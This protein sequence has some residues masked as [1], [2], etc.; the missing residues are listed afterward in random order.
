MVE[1]RKARAGEEKAI[2][3]LW[4]QVFGDDGAFLAEFYRLCVPYDQ[5]LVLAEDSVV[6][7]I[8]CAPEMTMR[9]PN[10]K[11]L[12]CGYMYALAT[13]PEARNQGF[14]REMMR[15]GEAHLKNEGADCAILVPAEPS[16]FRFFDSLDYVPAFSHL[17][18]EVPGDQVVPERGADPATPGEYN[19]LR[20]HWLK[21]RCYAD[22]GDDLVEFQRY[23]SQGTG[24]DLY[25]LDLPGGAGCAAVELDGE[26]AMVK[27]LLCAPVDLDRGPAPCGALYSAVACLGQGIRRAGAVGG[28][29]LA[30]RPA[31][32]L[33]ARR[34]GCLSRAG[35]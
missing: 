35:F 26:T 16:L 25:R 8:L 15:Y 3:A 2:A 28:G 14:G 31:V 33:V 13:D 7:S 18:R 30:L 1:L 11:A 29:P 17:R 5:M 27:E 9:L 4:G 32:A 24:G 12:K 19:S 34:A 23:L 6:R 20:R 21:G 22:Y 10:E